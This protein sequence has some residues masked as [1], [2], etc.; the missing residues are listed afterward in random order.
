MPKFTKGPWRLNDTFK[1]K[2]FAQTEK[3]LMTVCDIRGWGHLTGFGGFHLSDEAAIEIQDANAALI[4]AAP[5]MFEALKSAGRLIDHRQE[6]CWATGPATGD[7][8]ED[9]IVCPGCRVMA[10]INA[11][12][13]KAEPQ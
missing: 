5:E 4:A 1:S 13:K 7:A 6:D 12:L 9:L 8:I 11:V 2:V 3:G 10:E